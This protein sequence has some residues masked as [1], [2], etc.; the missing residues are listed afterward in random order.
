[1][2]RAFAI[3]PEERHGFPFPRPATTNT[4]CF[5]KGYLVRIDRA[6]SLFFILS[7]CSSTVHLADTRL[8]SHTPLTYESITHTST[9]GST[10]AI[11][12]EA[13]HAPTCAYCLLSFPICQLGSHNDRNIGTITTCSDAANRFCSSSP[14]CMNYNR[15]ASVRVGTPI[16]MRRHS[17]PR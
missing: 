8:H 14:F 9:T 5:L 4:Q 7:M 17:V 6:W 11:Y 2:A 13:D 16:F 12:G 10:H 15:L 3:R 1:M